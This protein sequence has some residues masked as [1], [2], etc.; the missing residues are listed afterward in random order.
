MR[1]INMKLTGSQQLENIAVSINNN[2]VTFKQ[3]EFKNL[4]CNYETDA[5]KINIK[6][7]K[8]LD[9]GGIWWFITQLFFFVISIF[10]IFDVHLKNRYL[11]L[12]Y[13]GEVELNDNND[14]TINCK[15]PKEDDKAF[16]IQTDLVVTEKNNKCFVDE[17]AKKTFKTLLISKIIL[18]L[19]IIAATIIILISV[20]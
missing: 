6:I 3:N 19:A 20:L 10:G 14:L 1:T 7:Y 12:I 5:S 17:K 11:G 13:E 8:M 9:V 18:A 16:E 2:P 4:V 15:I